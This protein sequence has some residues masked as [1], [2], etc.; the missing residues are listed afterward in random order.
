MKY[1]Y[2]SLLDSVIYAGLKG[3]QY[4]LRCADT[5]DDNHDEKGKKLCDKFRES[6]DVFLQDMRESKYGDMCLVMT[7]NQICDNH[8]LLLEKQAKHFALLKWLIEN[9]RLKISYYSDMDIIKY[10]ENMLE[11]CLRR[12]CKGDTPA[13][14][15]YISSLFPNLGEGNTGNYSRPGVEA[16]LGLPGDHPLQYDERRKKYYYDGKYYSL[17]ELISKF[18]KEG[19]LTGYLYIL[20]KRKQG[21]P[22]TDNDCI[23]TECAKSRKNNRPETS[24]KVLMN[25]VNNIFAL[26]DTA[27]RCGAYMPNACSGVNLQNTISYLLNDTAGQELLDKQLDRW[28][29][30]I[31]YRHEMRTGIKLIIA[32]LSKKESKRSSIYTKVKEEMN[33]YA[34]ELRSKG[35]EISLIKKFVTVRSKTD[36]SKDITFNYQHTYHTILLA[37]DLAYNLLNMQY[38]IG[39]GES[40]NAAFQLKIGKP[41]CWNNFFIVRN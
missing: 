17:Q 16:L 21:N 33:L 7:L 28:L 29:G 35:S 8:F 36:K 15:I 27:E 2:S 31:K 41:T 25:W 9:G 14:L 13:E 3:H 23:L 11:E 30:N 19:A 37:L 4:D 39:L 5:P 22:V 34:D 1:V 26:H 38:A 18:E 6:A 32:R 24:P 12:L 40:F 10:T 20:H